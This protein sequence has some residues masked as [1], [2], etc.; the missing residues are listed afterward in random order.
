LTL[1]ELLVVIAIVGLL[2]GLLLPA[3]QSA[4]EAA[5]RTQCVNNLRQLALAMHNYH[6]TNRRLPGFINSVGGPAN[7]MASWPIMLFPYID[8]TGLWSIWSKSVAQPAGANPLAPVQGLMCPSD[9]FDD[10]DG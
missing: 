3:I 4:R 6:D 9:E 5:R 8:E 10:C 1:V 2:M 7:R